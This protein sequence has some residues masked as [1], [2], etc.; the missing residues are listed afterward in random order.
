QA[1]TLRLLILGHKAVAVI[2]CKQDGCRR[3]RALDH[4]RRDKAVATTGHGLD[5]AALGAP[6]IEDAA[7]RGD[8]HVQVAV[9]DRGSRPDGLDD[10]GSRYE[11]PWPL[12]QHAENVERARTDRNRS[13]NTALIAP[14]QNTR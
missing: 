10:L 4:Y 12:D 1:W 8:L 5:A 14:K 11:I 9:F 2:A 13:E 6:V 3:R 7:Q